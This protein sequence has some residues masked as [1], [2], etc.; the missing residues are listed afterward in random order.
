MTK[1]VEIHYISAQPDEQYFIWQTDVYLSNFISLGIAPEHCIALFGYKPGGQPSTA[2][3]ALCNKYPTVDIR[4]YQ[5]TRDAI[6]TD[7]QASIQP[8]L[9]DKALKQ[10]SHL[11]YTRSFYHDCDIAFRRLPDFDAITM[12]HPAACVLSN[13]QDYIGYQYLHSCCKNISADN[14][15]I[16]VNE[17]IFKMCEVVGIDIETLR[18]H[19]STSGGA[20]YLLKGVGRAYWQKVYRD[21]IAIRRLF[22]DY[23]VNRVLPKPLDS[24]IQIWTAGM[25]S[26]LWNLWYFGFETV[27]HPEMNFSFANASSFDTSPILHMTGL[28]NDQKY[29]LFDKTDWYDASPIAVLK[30]QPFLFDHCPEDSVARKYTDLIHDVADIKRPVIEPAKAAKNWRLLAW[31]VLSEGDIWEIEQFDFIADGEASIVRYFDSGN[32]DAENPFTNTTSA[33]GETLWKV[34]CEI[35]DGCR[36]CLYIG[37]ELSQPARPKSIMLTQAQSPHVAQMAILQCM[38][39]DGNWA[40]VDVAKLDPNLINQTIYYHSRLGHKSNGWRIVA[41][42]T[43]SDFAWD[44]HRLAFLANNQEQRGTSFSSGFVKGAEASVFGPANAFRNNAALW[45]GR[46]N[47]HSRFLLGCGESN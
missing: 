20:Q 39:D 31:C 18:D 3:S 26:Y 42:S 34:P 47:A 32:S 7:Y 11:E 21:S 23:S 4:I 28:E 30:K 27:I 41:D 40:T 15:D 44:V 38:L 2:L 6:G 17:L 13:T 19:E 16:P 46:A 36:D 29:S 45:G 5:D 25:W 22:Q 24:Y 33:N 14:A 37:V 8:H 12:T 1:N 43:S 10:S 9:I 35:N